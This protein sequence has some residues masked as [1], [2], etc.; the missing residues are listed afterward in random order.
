[1]RKL[2]LGSSYAESSKN[3]LGQAKRAGKKFNEGGKR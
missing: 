2:F 1:M 3:T